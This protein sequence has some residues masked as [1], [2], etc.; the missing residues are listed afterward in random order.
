MG[1]THEVWLTRLLLIAFVVIIVFLPLHTF[2]SNWAGATFGSVLVWKTGPELLMM[3]MLP[4]LLFYYRVRPD[5]A[6]KI[7]R[8]WLTLLIAVYIVLNIGYGIISLASLPAIIAGMLMNM[9]FVAMLLLAQ[10][11][12][13]SGD[14]WV[15]AVRRWLEPWIFI[16]AIALSIIAI[17]QVT[18][19]PRDFLTQFGYNQDT[20]APYITVDQH[21]DALRAFATMRG[22][23]PLGEYL[24]LPIVLAVLAILR[25][26][27]NLLAGF[28]LGLGVVAMAATG[29]R[30]A[31]LGAIVAVA[32]L[33]A[34]S[35]PLKKL[36]VGVAWAFV[37]VVS[38][39]FLFFWVAANVPALR[40]AVFHSTVGDSSLTE[41]SL[42][43]HWQ[44]TTTG[45]VDAWQHP[46]GQGV[47]TAGPASFYNT[48]SAPKI[49][50]NYFIQIAEELGFIGLGVFV[51]INIVVGYRLWRQ[52]QQTWPRVLFAS[53][54]G[55][56]LVNFFLHGWSDDP[57][58]MTW[59]GI[60][61][62]FIT[63]EN[64]K[65]KI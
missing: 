55:L 46:L 57:T 64:W 52:R 13:A 21:P 2:I 48:A 8:S 44:A 35:V 45:A 6:K 38:L 63:T 51:F 32:A 28:T 1:R 37:P 40:L 50:E 42:D 20:T 29:S 27:R 12:A 11:I 3:A 22:P 36:L 26:P 23:N 24:I 16:T 14:S 34:A 65:D 7:S 33:V 43:K 25:E 62:L 15:V 59:W 9:R 5:V 53:F 61:G 31:W 49:P 19:L 18:V 30:S 41:G 17:L 10:A 4:L 56:T 60:A 39:T 58:S 47:G 54:I